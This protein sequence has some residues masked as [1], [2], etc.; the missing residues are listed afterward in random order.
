M[1]EIKELRFNNN[2]VMENLE[3][4]CEAI[5]AEVL[6]RRNDVHGSLFQNEGTNIRLRWIRIQFTHL[7]CLCENAAFGVY[8]G[9]ELKCA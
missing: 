2:E 6:S 7:R 3:G 5:H 4:V 9:S 1:L 8:S